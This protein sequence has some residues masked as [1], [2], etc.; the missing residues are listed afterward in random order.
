MQS[1]PSFT[2]HN[3]FQ[4]GGRY[5]DILIDGKTYGASKKET[6]LLCIAM[7]KIASDEIELYEVCDELHRF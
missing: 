5:S 3:K 2:I 6:T 7:S 4:K 1:K